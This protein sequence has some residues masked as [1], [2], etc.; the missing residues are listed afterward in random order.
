MTDDREKRIIDGLRKIREH[1]E[2]IEDRQELDFTKPI[3]NFFDYP[4]RLHDYDGGGRYPIHGALKIDNEWLSCA[5][6]RTGEI[7]QDSEQHTS[8]LNIF[9]VSPMYYYED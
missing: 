5:W 4:F 2:S 1:F 3:V 7:F 9:N 6:S 8:D